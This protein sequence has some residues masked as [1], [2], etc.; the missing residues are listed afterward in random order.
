MYKLMI[1]FAAAALTA[2]LSMTTVLAQNS[3]ETAVQQSPAVSAFV[4]ENG[5]GIC[6]NAGSGQCRGNGQGYVDAN[7]DGICDNAGN[8]QNYIDADGNGVCDNAETG[9]RMGSCHRANWNK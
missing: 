2:G 9:V 8:R 6:D 3:K 4:D 7:N 5:D 1:G